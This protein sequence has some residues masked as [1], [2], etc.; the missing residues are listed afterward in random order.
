M[1]T[2]SRIRQTVGMRDLGMEYV[3]ETDLA[4]VARSRAF[5][6]RSGRQGGWVSLIGGGLILGTAAALAVGVGQYFW[7]VAEA[8]PGLIFGADG[9]RKLAEVRSLRAQWQLEDLPPVAM[10]LSAAGLRCGADSV[11]LPWSAVAGIRRTRRRRQWSLVVDLAPGVTD[12]TPGVEGLST[13][14][15]ALRFKE[16]S[17]RRRHEEIDQAMSHFTNGRVR[18][19]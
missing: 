19:R 6:L 17:L 10:R 14:P 8:V 4:A 16:A 3:V 13:H 12:A 5:T 15:D 7:A 9:A 2:L 18:I 11:F 1:T